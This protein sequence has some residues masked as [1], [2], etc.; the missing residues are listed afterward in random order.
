MDKQYLPYVIGAVVVALVLFRVARSRVARPMNID[1]LWITPAIMLAFGGVGSWA[2]LNFP[3][4]A[5]PG[6]KDFAIMA[7]VLLAGAAIGWWRGRFMRIEVHPETHQV[8]VQA[9]VMAILVLVGLFAVRMG[10][11]SVFLGDAD[12]RSP[13]AALLNVDFILVAIGILSVARMEMWL[14]AKRLLNEA[15][16]AK[17]A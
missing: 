8:M 1:L 11:R 13:A 16:A 6:L 3:H 7:A 17:A 9:S 2:M 4:P 15:R 14:R 5:N 10:L 12:P